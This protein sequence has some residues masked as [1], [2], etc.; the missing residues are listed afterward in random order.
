MLAD[1]PT[2]N[3]D[4]VSAGAIVELLFELHAAGSTIVVVT[5]D[6]ELAER[7]PRRIS[8]R[9]GLICDPISERAA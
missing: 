2:G 4:S 5:H 9:D 3:L 8:M 1:E 6:R 7:F